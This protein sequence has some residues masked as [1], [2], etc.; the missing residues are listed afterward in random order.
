MTIDLSCA[1]LNLSQM[2]VSYEYINP[3]YSSETYKIKTFFIVEFILAAH[4]R[5][6]IRKREYKPV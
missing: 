2:G 6:L 4:D 1:A 5:K 3:I